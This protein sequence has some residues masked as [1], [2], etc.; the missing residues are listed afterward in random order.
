MAGNTPPGFTG[1]DPDRNIAEF[2]FYWTPNDNDFVNLPAEGD[3]SS[4]VFRFAHNSDDW[5]GFY[6]D[7]GCGGELQL[8]NGG[9]FTNFDGNY[10][11]HSTNNRGCD[12]GRGDN[13]YGGGLTD[14]DYGWFD[15]SIRKYCPRS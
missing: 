12:S 3:S 6:M 4:E 13:N 10:N 9:E 5:G 2:R 14:H 11:N 15:K 1:T 7:N 8:G